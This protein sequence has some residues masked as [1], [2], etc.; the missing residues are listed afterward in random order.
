MK[1]KMKEKTKKTLTRVCA[2]LLFFVLTVSAVVL[3]G[4]A[5]KGFQN[6]ASVIFQN[7]NNLIHTLDTY[8]SDEG[9]DTFGITWTVLGNR[10]VHAEGENSS[11]SDKAFYVVGDVKIEDTDYYTLS[12][13]TDSDDYWIEATY[14]SNGEDVIL[15][16][17]E[18]GEDTSAEK[19][20]KGTIVTI[21][22]YVAIGAEVDVRVFL[23]F[24]FILIFI[25]KILSI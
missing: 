5:T 14:S 15:S 13:V 21:T 22:L 11:A 20:Q 10:K 2:I 4:R 24:S 9:E 3:L 16:T 18:D 12:G 1:I 6:D 25:L 19:I 17:A 7:K 23:V 8:D